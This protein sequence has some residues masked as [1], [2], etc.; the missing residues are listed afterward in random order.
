MG[1]RRLV[2]LGLGVAGVACLTL[3][4]LTLARGSAKCPYCFSP[5]VRS[6]TPTLVD[7]LLYLIYIRPYRCQAC[8]KRFYARRRVVTSVHENSRPTKPRT[9]AAGGSSS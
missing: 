3:A 2:F 5:R 6:S 9:K 1:I 4:I 8:L 7:K